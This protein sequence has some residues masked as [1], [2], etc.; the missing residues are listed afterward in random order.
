MRARGRPTVDAERLAHL[1]RRYGAL[2]QASLSPRL[3]PWCG[4][5]DERYWTDIA[6]GKQPW[7]SPRVLWRPA[8]SSASASSVRAIAS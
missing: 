7:P 6:A 1:P 3:T 4:R 2:P 5:V 8:I